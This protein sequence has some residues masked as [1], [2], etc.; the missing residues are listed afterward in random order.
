MFTRPEQSPPGM[1]M[2]EEAPP[3]SSMTAFPRIVRMFTHPGEVA[4]V[5]QETDHSR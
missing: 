4:V 5:D 2:T 1:A 3:Q